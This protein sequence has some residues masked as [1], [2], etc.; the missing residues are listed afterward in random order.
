MTLSYA[1]VVNNF[2]SPCIYMPLSLLRGLFPLH[3]LLSWT[4]DLLWP[5][6][7]GGSN[8]VRVSAKTPSGFHLCLLATLSFHIEKSRQ[9]S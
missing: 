3:S 2:F 5:V 9:T 1:V 7:F 6:K 4:F 8:I